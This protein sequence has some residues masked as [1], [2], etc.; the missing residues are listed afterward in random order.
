MPRVPN[1]V[2][3]LASGLSQFGL[4][5]ELA[6][7][8]TLL[9][10]AAL[11]TG[12]AFIPVEAARALLTLGPALVLPGAALLFVLGGLGRG[13]DRYPSLILAVI[14][15]IAFYPLAA[16]VVYGLGVRLSP[17]SIVTALDIW[18]VALVL[19]RL[20]LP[21]KLWAGARPLLRRPQ[22]SSESSW[23]W[24]IWVLAVMVAGAAVIGL[25][26]TR[27]PQ[28][29][30]QPYLA[31]HF[32]GSWAKTSGVRS[33]PA[34]AAVTVPLSIDNGS[35]NATKLLV[36]TSLDGR[37]FGYSRLVSLSPHERWYGSI[38]GNMTGQGCLQQL[39]VRVRRP[40]SSTTLVSVDMW[41][42]LQL[43][44]CKA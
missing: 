24:T 26:I 23:R 1:R 9:L 37:P 43:A 14:L 19:I 21:G 28:P 25:G 34:K 40:S 5:R 13:Y 7:A 4:S 33:V 20:L 8:S 6:L 2:G 16:L 38:V 35:A 12:A 10:A 3:R 17:K 44:T 41:L 39:V 30:P 32:T 29:A 31:L 27:L 11:V 18:V 36:Q 22:A 42:S 15:S